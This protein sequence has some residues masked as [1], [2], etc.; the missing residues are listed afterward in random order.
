MTESERPQGL[1][2]EQLNALGKMW[3]EGIGKPRILFAV[4]DGK[5][6]MSCEHGDITP[7]RIELFNK[8][9]EAISPL[10][11]Q[12]PQF[13]MDEEGSLYRTEVHMGKISLDEEPGEENLA[14]QTVNTEMPESPPEQKQIKDKS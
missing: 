13:F 7:E 1:S 10:G 9:Q 5:G 3:D 8:V 14:G 2:G 11:P 4:A 6:G 12:F